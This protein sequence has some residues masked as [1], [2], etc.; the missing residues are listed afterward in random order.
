MSYKVTVQ[1]A[2]V[3]VVVKSP[4]GKYATIRMDYL[5]P[6]EMGI[7]YINADEGMD[8]DMVVHALIKHFKNTETRLIRAWFSCI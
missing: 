1:N 6:T 8:L 2:R 4:T 3:S 7:R 5:T